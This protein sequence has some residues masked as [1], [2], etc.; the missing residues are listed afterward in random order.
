MSN[1]ILIEL[2]GDAS[3][4]LETIF[5]SL[6]ANK[7][8]VRNYELDHICYRVETI[9]RYEA[10]KKALSPLGKLL[11]ESQI[12]GRSIATFQLHKPI[13]FQNRQI[14]VLELPAPKTGSFYKEGFEHVEFVIDTPF[15]NFMQ[16]HSHLSFKTKGMSK[17]VNPEI[18]LRYDDFAV[19]FHHH[20]LAYVIEFLD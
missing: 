11:V 10:L 18:S 2:L 13:V 15:E 3:P 7:V 14:H 5:Q 8:D 4:F 19:K 16:K 9:E 1:K 12:G 20:T 17:A 6:E